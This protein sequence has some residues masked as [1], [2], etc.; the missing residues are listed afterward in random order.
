MTLIALLP[1]LRERDFHAETLYSGA[2]VPTDEPL[3]QLVCDRHRWLPSLRWRSQAVLWRLSGPLDIGVGNAGP[4]GGGSGHD[5]Q[6]R[7]FGDGAGARVVASRLGGAVSGPGVLG[8]IVFGCAD[9]SSTRCWPSGPV[10]A[11]RHAAG[12]GLA[13]LPG[14]CGGALPS[15]AGDGAWRAA[16]W[17]TAGTA[18]GLGSAC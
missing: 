10:A 2:V 11:A 7:Q 6:P 12:V 14:I 1:Q 9:G 13:G 5:F 15:A 17:R 16:G 4:G 8:R 3:L 18:Q